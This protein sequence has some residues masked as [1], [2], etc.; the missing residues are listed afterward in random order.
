MPVVS[1]PKRLRQ[2]RTFKA[3][4]G[5]TARPDLKKKVNRNHHLYRIDLLELKRK[6]PRPS[7]YWRSPEGA[8]RAVGLHGYCSLSLA[9]GSVGY[10]QRKLSP[11]EVFFFFP[12]YPQIKRACLIREELFRGK[13]NICKSPATFPHVSVLWQMMTLECLGKDFLKADGSGFPA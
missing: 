11:S 12:F 6:K 7:S 10:L 3:R 9:R 5:Y 13:L 8:C 2:D 4:A 1:G